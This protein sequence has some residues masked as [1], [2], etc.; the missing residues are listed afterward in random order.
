MRTA[1]LSDSFHYVY[2]CDL[3]ANLQ[4]KICDFEG[5]YRDPH[6][7][8]RK[9]RQLCAQATVY[10]NGRAVGYSVMTSYKPPP[11][12]GEC[13]RN[14]LIQSWGEWLTFA[15]PSPLPKRLVAQSSLPLFSKRG[16]FKSGTLDI[17][18]E[19]SEEL[20]PL[21]RCLENWKSGDPNDSHLNELLKQVSR[22]QRNLVNEVPWLDPFTFRKVEEVRNSRKFASTQR[23]LFLVI[24]MA[25]IQYDRQHYD[26]VYYEDPTPDLR[27]VAS[28]GGG[29]VATASSRG[30]DPEL[31]L[32]N[33]AETKHN[34]M[35]R[36]AR[37]GAMDKQLK[38]NKQTKDRLEAIIRLPPSQ[39]LSREQARSCVEVSL[40]STS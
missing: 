4:V 24:K 6:N 3:T 23:Y 20:D 22:Q 30:F 5:K 34:V 19:L 37:A 31:G 1:T 36:N 16:V 17:Q 27:I 7:P 26:V 25:S 18:M 11:E 13:T 15:T 21:H 39:S 38:P 35:T 12:D 29:S 9:L 8:I 14:K 10:C 28:V 33:L 40:L 32:E 2:S